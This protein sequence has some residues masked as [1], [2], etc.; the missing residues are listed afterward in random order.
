ML[1]F[2]YISHYPMQYDR[3][4]LSA[5]TAQHNF[6]DIRDISRHQGGYRSIP[7]EGQAGLMGQMDHTIVSWGIGR[8][9][10]Q[11]GGRRGPWGGNTQSSND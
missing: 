11:V 2:H 4:S 8:G 5:K 7:C 1:H 3:K 9:I 6:C 10:V